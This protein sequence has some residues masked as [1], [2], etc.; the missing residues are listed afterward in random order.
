MERKKVLQYAQ[1]SCDRKNS[2][3]YF[4][5]RGVASSCVGKALDNAFLE[6]IVKCILDLQCLGVAT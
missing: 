1:N 3:T 2:N 4:T 5:L 6:S